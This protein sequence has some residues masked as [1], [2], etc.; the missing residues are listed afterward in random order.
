MALLGNMI[1]FLF[2][3]W[4]LFIGYALAAIVFFPAAIPLF[5]LAIYSAWPFG[6][7]VVSQSELSRYRELTGRHEQLGA[8]E[9]AFRG[10][11]GVL[12]VLWLLT[13]GW[14]L[15]LTHLLAS[16]A[17]VFVI[18]L[19]VT[20][21]NITGHLKLIPVALLPFNKVIVPA[22]IAD[23]VRKRLSQAKLNI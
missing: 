10:L 11:S 8:T 13:F 4:A 7:A 21:P 15:A 17:N 9:A 18:W 12:N 16:I 22:S 23:D 1:W 19:I 2:G 5:R 14:L 6:R 3:G 20:I